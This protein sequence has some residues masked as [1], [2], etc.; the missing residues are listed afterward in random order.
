[1]T[2][3]PSP[4]VASLRKEFG[5]AIERH[6]VSCGDSIVYAS[7]ERVHDVLAWLKETPGEN[8]S[9]LTD[10]TAVDYRDLG[11]CLGAQVLARALDRPADL[12]VMVA[13]PTG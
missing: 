11:I 13:I 6:V 1:M 3:A 10:I 4:S 5:E 2:A 9:Y 8:Y 7:R 12:G